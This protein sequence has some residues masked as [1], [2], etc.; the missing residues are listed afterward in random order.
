MVV[1]P[2]RV[3]GDGFQTA[4]GCGSRR[5]RVNSIVGPEI[6]YISLLPDERFQMVDGHRVIESQGPCLFTIVPKLNL[7]ID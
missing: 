7:V 2:Q 4:D 6:G 5:P 3:T 1:I